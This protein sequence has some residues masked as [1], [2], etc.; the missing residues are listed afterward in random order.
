MSCQ[1][2]VA[3][4]KAR[5]PAFAAFL[6]LWAVAALA[7][8]ACLKPVRE[9]DC[10]LDRTCECK[11]RSDCTDGKDCID[12]HCV[13]LVDAGRPGELG[14]PCAKDGD[15]LFGPCLAKGP[16]NGQVCSA[17]CASDGGVPCGKGWECKSP[18][19][20]AAD[21]CVPPFQAL[22]LR[23]QRDTD[24]N[25]AGDRCLDLGHG[26][27]ACGQD[28]SGS[29]CPTG[30]ECRALALDA[31]IAHQ[32]VPTSGTCECSAV[33]V[34]LRRTCSRANA[35][36]RCFGFETC[37]PDSSWNGCDARDA[38]P[39]VCD[40]VDNDCNGLTDQYDPGMDVSKVPGYPDCRKG[41]AC[42]GKVYC[43]AVGPDAGYGFLCS[44]PDPRQ[45]TCNGVDDD[46]NGL[47]DDGLVDG[48]GHYFNVRACG[49]CNADCLLD[50]AHLATDGGLDAGPLPNAAAC[51]MAGSTPTCVPRACAKGF[52]LNSTTQPASCEQAASPEC[53]PC[54]SA[55]DCVVPG[56]DCQ[57]VGNEPGK[58]C[59][60]A[61][62]V[63]A[64]YAGC[65]GVVGQQGCCPTGS[66]CEAVAGQKLCTPVGGSCTCTPDR[67]GLTRGCTR[68]SGAATCLG[69]Q[70][71]GPTGYGVCDTSKTAVEFCD[72]LDNDC[73]GIVDDGFINTRGTRTYDTDEHCGNCT[74]N[75]TVR[76]N[77]A[78]QHAVGG[79]VPQLASAPQCRIVQCTTTTVA[80]G[81]ACR[82]DADC[83]GGRTC[84]PAFHQCVRACTA[85]SPC[86]AGEQCSNGACT[87]ACGTAAE[88]TQAYG[89]GSTCGPDRLCAV[90][91]QFNDTNQDD[92][93]G[94]ECASASGVVDT[95]DVS[96]TYPVAGMPYVDRDCDGLD[97]EEATSLF[98]WARS[99]SSQ[100]TRLAPYRTLG[101]AIAAFRPGVH[102][103]ILVAQGT[104]VEQVVLRDG[105]SLHGG[106]SADFRK[107]DVVT[108]PTLVEAPEPDPTVTTSRRGTVNAEGLAA[109]TVFAGFT[110]R[111]YDVLSRPLPGQ[112][113]R[114]SYAVYVKNAPNLVFANNHVVGGRGGDSTPGLPGLA[115][116]NGGYGRDGV[117]TRECASPECVGETQ[118]G[119]VGGLNGACLGG[120][121]GQP[122]A[123]TDLNLDPQQYPNGSPLNGRG[124][125]NATY[126]HSDPSQN[127]FCK[128]DCTVPADGLAGGAARN[129]D[130]G[131]VGQGGTAC[132]TAVGQLTGDDWA[133]P[134]G[135]AGAGGVAGRGG[136]GGGGGGCVHNRNPATCTIGRLVGDLG[137]TGGGG[138]A[139]G[140]GGN[141]GMGAGGGGASIAIFILGG[142]PAL[143]GN[144]VDLGFGGIGGN[145]G[146]GGYGGLGG[147]GGRG[148]VN[149]TAAWCAGQGGPG[150]RGGNGGPGAGGGGGCGGSVFGVA[151]SGIAAG[152]YDTRN[153]FAPLPMNAAGAGGLGGRS[154][155]AAGAGADGVSGTVV[156]LQSF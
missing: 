79:C 60:Q 83:A 10:L 98:V 80:G 8:A 23:C 121:S 97:G 31:G 90:T 11:Q 152:A 123:G 117:P 47:V 3:G 9:P 95:P 63:S 113:A 28:C 37:Q 153:T 109:R 122:G 100:G 89:A 102:S 56:D 149:T 128:Y 76:W 142:L 22:C 105:V 4:A 155:A 110:V 139:G 55:G 30:F 75:C 108:Y 143:E 13:L 144:L 91:Y 86:G 43:G 107:R 85:T 57:P 20:G 21:L 148:G 147:P 58:F 32:C 136:G 150:G 70:V 52:F 16:G 51:V 19:P 126:A 17:T 112:A 93:D 101:E 45:E 29:A 27:K 2:V 154:P 61:C 34:G 88:C 25:A 132:A 127:A 78:I 129:G 35:I 125:A 82:V 69:Q 72:G 42:T 151:G 48:A 119:G 5:G 92:T 74:T 115:G 33:S 96:P 67:Q 135:G 24:C 114:N 145:G 87:R 84:D 146:A 94:C 14:W 15:C 124:G 141:A 111:G 46:C 65:T 62:D 104:Y 77:P 36:G 49:S 134:V 103:A 18:A 41:V 71:C 131:Q 7:G 137:G 130:D 120:T 116:D 54:T 12:G 81:G 53:R 106:Y 133:T 68:T 118:A 99:T 1:V 44:A 156:L 6:V 26:E 39:E 59:L 38:G 138:G 140:C 64:T 40:G 66:T 73:N 50:L